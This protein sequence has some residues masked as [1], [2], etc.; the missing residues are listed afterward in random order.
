M[1]EDRPL[2][3]WL[4]VEP[5]VYHESGRYTGLPR[6]IPIGKPIYETGTGRLVG[7]RHQYPEFYDKWG[8]PL[9]FGRQFGPPPNANAN[10][11]PFMENVPTPAHSLIPQKTYACQNPGCAYHGKTRSAL[12][13]HAR[14]HNG[15]RRRKTRRARN[16]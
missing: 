9:R 2:Q 7:R 13:R 16:V 3:E 14:S 10:A 8:F 15:G 12:E 4:S 5:L 11:P 1:A 6:Y